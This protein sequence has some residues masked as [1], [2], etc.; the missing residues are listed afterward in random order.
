MSTAV[1]VLSLYLSRGLIHKNLV[2]KI[3]E[4][5]YKPLINET[6]NSEFVPI[7]LEL[8]TLGFNES[9]TTV[10]TQ[11]RYLTYERLN[12]TN[13]CLRIESSNVTLSDIFLANWQ[14]NVDNFENKL[15]G[16]GWDQKPNKPPLSE[17]YMPENEY[18]IFYNKIVG[19]VRCE[20]TFG[21]VNEDNLGGVGMVCMRNVQFFGGI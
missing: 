13:N 21:Q 9:I 6:F 10:P 17:M 7:K 2:P 4:R 12:F 16:L 11:C 20:L 8:N 15:H 18:G 3:V 19:S 1:L 14:S 5:T